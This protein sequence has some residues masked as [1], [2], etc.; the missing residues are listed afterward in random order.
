VE[1]WPWRQCEKRWERKY[2][3]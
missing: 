2:I 3:L 1:R